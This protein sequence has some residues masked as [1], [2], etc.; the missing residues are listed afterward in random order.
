[1]PARA[2]RRA[3]SLSRVLVAAA[4]LALPVVVTACGATPG[5]SADTL[6]GTGAVAT[7]LRDLAPFTRVSVGAGMKVVIGEADEQQVAVAAQP[8]L[9]PVIETEV[10]D[11]QLIVTLDAPFVTATEPMTLTLRMTGVE[12]VALSGGAVGYVEH[13]GGP[14]NLDVSGGAQLTAI[15][16]TT[17]LRLTAS[18]G[19]HAKLGELTA[20]RADIDVNDGSSVE[21]HAVTSVSGTADGGATVTLTT[22][23]ARV[24]V[25][26]QSGA[27]VQGG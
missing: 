10:A 15:G 26:T 25:E 5:A 11:G 23:P 1:M 7:E 21:L 3:V 13:T 2:S 19:S 8:N 9:L 4:A 24:D 17:E 16:D 20:D 6:V 27:S 14:L 18:S 22:K 12:S